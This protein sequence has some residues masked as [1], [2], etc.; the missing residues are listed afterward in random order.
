MKR[1][2]HLRWAITWLGCLF[3]LG[4]LILPFLPETR[5]KDLPT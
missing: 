4:L 3:I 1:I 2:L 5:G